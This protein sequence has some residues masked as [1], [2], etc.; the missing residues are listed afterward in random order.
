[1]G[2]DEKKEE[3]KEKEEKNWSAVNLTYIDSK[4]PYKGAFSPAAY[5]NWCWFRTI[6]PKL[7]ASK[8]ALPEIDSKIDYGIEAVEAVLGEYAPKL[9]E[10]KKDKKDKKDDKKDKKKKK[11]KKKKKGEKKKKKKKKKS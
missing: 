6:R 4:L 11:K 8:G 2:K 7:S 9:E 5:T 3:E 10:E 1:M